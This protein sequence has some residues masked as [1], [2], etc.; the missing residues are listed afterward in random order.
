MT[1]LV[2]VLVCRVMGQ[3]DV[4]RISGVITDASGASVPACTVE[5]TNVSTKYTQTVRT[6][7]TGVYIFASLPVGT[8]DLHALHSG[9]RTVEQLGVVLDASSQRSINFKLEVGAIS[10]SVSV[11]A[12]AEQVQTTSGDINRVISDTQVSQIALNGNNYAQLLRLI[13]GVM[14]TDTNPFGMAL[15]TTTQRVNGV[16]TMSMNWMVD[17]TLNQDVGVSINQVVSPNVDSIAEVI[18]NTS[19]Y[20]AE[21]A[22]H[23]G[24]VVNVVGKSGTTTYHGS[25]FEYVRNNLFDARSFFAAKVEP[26]RFNDFGWTLGGPIYFPGKWNSDKSKLFFFA[27]QEWKYSHQ[28]LTQVDVVPT[29]AERQG[30]FQSDNL[31]APADP[32]TKAPYPNRIVPRTAWSHN[33]PLLLNA[34]PLPNF[35]GSGGNY[36]VTGENIFDPRSD[37]VRIDYYLTPKLQL[38]YRWTDATNKVVQ[39]FY[40]NNL[41]TSSGQRTRPGYLTSL[42]LSQIISPTMLN[43]FTFNVTSDYI[44]GA[45]VGDQM[46]RAITGVNFPLIF[47]YNRSNIIPQL[48][49][50]GFTPINVYD[51]VQ[52]GFGY[53]TWRDDLSKVVGSHTFKFGLQ[54]ARGRRN[55]D[56][57][58]HDE[59]T[60]NFSTS[61]KLTS[62]NVLA[63]V[64]LGNFYTFTQD[65]KDTF[66][67]DRWNEYDLYAQDSWKVNRRLS[68]EFGLHYNV[69]PPYVNYQGNSATFVPRLYSAANAPVVSRADGSIVANTGVPY[70]GISILGCQFP[71]AANGR[72]PEYNDP[73]LKG[74]FHCLPRGGNYTNW[75]DWGPRVGL[76][77]DPFGTGKTAIRTGFGVF[78]DH[79][80]PDDSA[81]ITAMPPFQTSAKVFNGNIDNP[82]A[83]ATQQF[84]AN[85]TAWPLLRKDPSIMTWNFGVQQQLPQSVI[86]EVNYVGNVGRH[87]VRT[88]NI[89]QLPLGTL[90]PP[91]NTVNPNALNPYRGYGTISFYDNG[92]N[93]NYNA[94]QVAASRRM[95][96]GLSLGISYTFSKTL[97]ASGGGPNDTGMPQNS[98]NARPDYGLSDI[99]RRHVFN[100]NYIYELPFFERQANAIIRNTLGG[101]EIAG[102]TSFQSGAPL[103]I[104]VPVDAAAIGVSLSRATLTGDP[105]LPPDERTPARWYNT[106]VVVPP[107]Q[108]TPGQF[109]NSGRDILTG[110]GFQEWDLSLLKNF[111]MAEKWRLQFRAEAFNVPNHANFSSVGTSATFTSSGQPSGNFGAVSGSG[112]GRT[113]EFGLKMTF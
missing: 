47:P 104:T 77:Y 51:R 87:L 74:L 66:F 29:L 16:R 60:A 54:I 90:L 58:A 59:G 110:P 111:A 96:K 71:S 93:S 112:P 89:N 19:S 52:Q 63:D 7:D 22:G 28:A 106:S 27:S 79:T 31:A 33:G 99:D 82:G 3:S 6:D 32:N 91:N 105:N 4:G 30:N 10:E 34:Y 20:S 41:G 108:M 83:S 72:L 73:S 102:V 1:L 68:M 97:D 69:Y 39:A 94:L 86:L 81:G 61:A 21:F 107:S 56:T 25:L 38:L 40:G 100:I 35:T 57:K 44:H 62:K 95:T 67:Y 8:Y 12:S 98:Y 50:S 37:L 109:G 17:G 11:L 15:S 92:D 9:F 42:S 85:L 70:N 76:A 45:I 46:S 65:E 84:P 14:A 2:T 101:W 78:Y 64:L 49:I 88:L 53:F 36:V 5:A 55:Q 18:V 80:A 23:S 113:L 13:P 26:L 103:S 24:A 43:Y 48:S 75:N